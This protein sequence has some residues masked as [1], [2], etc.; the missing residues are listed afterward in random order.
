[1]S[2][3]H[4]EACVR[5]GK[6]SICLPWR[7][8]LWNRSQRV[9]ILRIQK[10]TQLH[11][12]G[13]PND[14]RKCQYFSLSW[15]RGYPIRRTYS[16]NTNTRGLKQQFNVHH[17]NHKLRGLHMSSSVE[18]IIMSR[19]Q[20]WPVHIQQLRRQRNAYIIL[21]KKCLGRETTR[22]HTQKDTHTWALR[23]SSLLSR[24]RKII[25]YEFNIKYWNYFN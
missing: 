23:V 15:A 17:K 12:E 3:A 22:H 5:G 25:N 7:A 18:K 13:W 16:I 11:L 8:A 24:W 4:L 2:L 21:V 6:A 1:M 14:I 20:G 9:L 10:L 19:R